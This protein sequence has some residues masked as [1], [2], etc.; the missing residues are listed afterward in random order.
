MQGQA[1]SLAPREM[2]ISD[3]DALSAQCQATDEASAHL[4]MR[5][6]ADH[7]PMV[8]LKTYETL[9]QGKHAPSLVISGDRFPIDYR[10]LLLKHSDIAFS[11]SPSGAYR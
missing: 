8:K 9:E 7:H 3:I 2:R 10:V 1:P 4:L 5:I 11:V 6:S